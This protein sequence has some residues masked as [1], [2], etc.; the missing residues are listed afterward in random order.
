VDDLDLD[1][2]LDHSVT[3]VEWGEGLVENLATGHLRLTIDRPE[4]EPESGAE[5]A[6]G[7]DDQVRHVTVAGYGD[8]WLEAA[9]ELT[10]TL[11]EPFA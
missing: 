4:Q 10:E 11:A 1:A 8:R 9:R 6:D 5:P 3:V 7:T 2:D